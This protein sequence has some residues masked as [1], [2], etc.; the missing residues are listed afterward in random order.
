MACTQYITASRHS[1]YLI[2]VSMGY[3]LINPFI[4]H[5]ELVEDV[6][7]CWKIIDESGDQIYMPRFTSSTDDALSGARI[8]VPGG[9]VDILDEEAGYC[10]VIREGGQSFRGPIRATRALAVIGAALE[11]H[12]ATDESSGTSPLRDLERSLAATLTAVSESASEEQANTLMDKASHLE[13]EIAQAPAETLADVAVKLRRLA[14]QW[15][16]GADSAW[17]HDLI[18]TALAGVERLT[19]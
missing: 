14:K 8:M 3:T 18:T 2:A 16:D 5:P 17:N 12:H 11:R 19:A 7:D 13:T 1:D 10:A 15:V 9:K 6:A 4:D